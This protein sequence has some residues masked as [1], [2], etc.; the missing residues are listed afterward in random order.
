MRSVL[1]AVYSFPEAYPPTL[2]AIEQ[3]AIR[4]ERVH[5]VSRNI[6]RENWPFPPNVQVHNSG[7]AVTIRESEQKPIYWKLFSLLRYALLMLQVLVRHKPQLALLCDPIPL[8]AYRMAAFFHV[9]KPR[10]WY[11]NHD[12]LD[13]QQL[14]RFNIS[15]LAWLNEQRFFSK[16]HY[17]SLPAQE[18]AAYFPMSA[19][20]GKYFFLPNLPSIA[21]YK[22]HQAANKRLD[23]QEIR[24]IYQGHIGSGHGLETLISEV[25][26][27][28]FRGNKCIL[29]LKGIV[30]EA[31]KERLTS[32]AAQA[33][34]GSQLRFYGFGP[35]QE[36]PVLTSQCH[37]GIGIHSGQDIMNK[38]LGTASNKIYEY[39]ALGLPVLLYRSAHYMQHFGHLNWV[40]FT[41]LEAGDLTRAVQSLLEDYPEKSAAA[42]RSFEENL[43]FEQHFLPAIAEIEAELTT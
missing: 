7:S 10:I 40:A 21:F 22:K 13:P 9:G 31:Y 4:A 23:E 41:T 42:R 26:P 27:Q 28:P 16:L 36:V 39:A 35:Y 6:E 8:L 20:R 17:F 1:V 2:N 37:I 25:L 30:S 12:V 24:L 32:L 3:L 38:T 34:V 11:H 14:T 5:V 19:F 15:R 29:V 18:R 33:N 43:N